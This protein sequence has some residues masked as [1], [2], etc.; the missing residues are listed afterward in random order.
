M[1]VWAVYIPPIAKCG[2][3]WGTRAEFVVRSEDKQRQVPIQGFF[4]KLRMTTSE[5]MTTSALIMG[6][7]ARR[8]SGGLGGLG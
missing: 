4:A 8:W 6:Y 5:G 3:G 7:P 1:G 2:D